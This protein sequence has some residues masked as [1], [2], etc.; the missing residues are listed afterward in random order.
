VNWQKAFLSKVIL[1]EEIKEAVNAGI[2]DKFFRDEQYARVYQFMLNHWAQHGT[3]PD[4][5]VVRQAYPT[6]QWDPQKQALSYLIEQMRRDR[7]LV[8]LTQGLNDAAEHMETEDA[9]QMLD[10]LSSALLQ[11]KLETSP[12]RDMDMTTGWEPYDDILQ[13]R[14]ENPGYLRG[15]STGFHGIDYVTGGFQPEQ[16]VVLL[17]T[18]KSFKSATL[19]AMA[20]AAHEQ[21][22]RALFSGYEMATQEQ[23]DRLASLY[24]GVSLNKILHGSINPK[25][26]RTV[27]KAMQA[28]AGMR[29]FIFSTDITAGTTVGALQA[30]I[31]DYTPDVVFV[32]G[33]YL[34]QS[35]ELGVIPGSPQAVTSI[36]R[37][38]KRLAQQQKVPIC[39]TT[40]ASLSRSRNGLSIHS[41]MYS[42]AWGQDCDVLLGVER[43]V[44]ENADPEDMSGPVSVKFRVL[45]SRSG[46]RKDVMLEWDWNHGLVEELDPSR[47]RALLSQK[48]TR[49]YGDQTDG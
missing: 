39:V 4:V 5:D 3:A 12:S 44:E 28:L 8:L 14:M 35:E 11:S 33:A 45:E 2:T 34:M 20:K 31:I 23:V 29:P 32:D 22:K 47:I 19:L 37:G 15:I 41:G 13:E 24:S 38:L 21:G 25:E 43:Q 7:K 40:Q 36:S 17:G 30:K 16:F 18:P 27:R 10:V 48:N 6:L 1:E 26:Y 9:D 49:S 46:P 42:Q